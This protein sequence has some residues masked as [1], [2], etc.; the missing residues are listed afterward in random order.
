MELSHTPM[1]PFSSNSLLFPAF[2]KIQISKT[3]TLHDSPSRANRTSTRGAA[4]KEPCVVRTS[5]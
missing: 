2:L 5:D 1:R 3:A 4:P